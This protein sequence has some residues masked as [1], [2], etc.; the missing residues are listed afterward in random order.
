[1]KVAVAMSV[2]KTDTFANLKLA[3]DS[4]L[5]QTYKEIDIFIQV[6]GVISEPC[7]SLLSDYSKNERFII[8]YNDVNSGL[9]TRLNDIIS[10]VVNIGS[11]GYIARM[12][13][14][15]IAFPERIS[16]QVAFLNNNLDISVVGTDL[17]EIS[18]SGKE[19]FHKKMAYNHDDIAKEII[20]KCPFS[21]PTVMFRESVFSQSSIRY[22]SELMNT[23]D[24][25]LWVD[26]LYG[27][28]KFANLPKPLLYFRVNDKFHSRR[29]WAKAM[30]DVRSRLYAFEKL[31]VIN[32]SNITHT[33]SL[34]LLRIAPTTIKKWAYKMLR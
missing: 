6:D 19:L 25:Y 5:N 10:D 9:A 15:D 17:I 18:D 16:E 21:H 29:G 32:L 23:Q 26:L 30:N 14:D 28:Y 34:F 2:Y 8:G 13:A 1:M 27:G 22:K 33:I 7:Y 3:I 20:K 31:N 24:Y 12:D 4:I 11:Y